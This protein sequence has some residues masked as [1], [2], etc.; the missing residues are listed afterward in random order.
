M[1][2]WWIVGL[3]LTTFYTANLTASLARPYRERSLQ[4][5]R[6]LSWPAYKDAKWLTLSDKPMPKISIYNQEVLQVW[7]LYSHLHQKFHYHLRKHLR[8]LL[9]FQPY[10]TS[11]TEFDLLSQ[12]LKTGRGNLVRSIHA[13]LNLTKRGNIK[14]LDA[15]TW[16]RNFFICLSRLHLVRST[17]HASWNNA[18]ELS[19]QPS[20]KRVTWMLFFNNR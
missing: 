1:A 13:A 16:C 6:E 15:E 19:S 17:W 18:G 9:T 4:H 12:H 2:T 10:Q 11:T 7:L 20:R 3:L 5:P 14:N 8:A